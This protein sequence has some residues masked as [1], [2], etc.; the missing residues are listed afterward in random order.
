MLRLDPGLAF[1]TGSHATT[2][3]CLEWLRETLRPGE[4]V[5]DYGCGSGII[6]IAAAKLGA[7]DATGTDIDPQAIVAS[8]ANAT[9]N[10]V[11]ARFVTPDRLAA[12]RHDVVVA[13][14]LA[15]PLVLLA[16]ALAART[17]SRGRIT[18]SGI[19][20]AQAAEVV[21]SYTPWFTLAVWRQ[22]DGWV[23][24]AGSRE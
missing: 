23:L 5:L 24:I 20:E 17:A 13:N 7:R 22:R 9:L 11:D 3:L 16:P 2:H 18:L 15:H 12:G 19:L 6:A 21:A 4:S 14:I 1:G 10:G 8:R